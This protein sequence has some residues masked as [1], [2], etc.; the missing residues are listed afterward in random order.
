MD[1]LKTLLKQLVAIPSVNPDHTGPDDPG[2]GE[3]AFARFIRDY[4]KEQGIQS[5]LQKVAP[6]RHNVICRLPGRK[7]GQ[8]LIFLSHLDTI[9]STGMTVPPFKGIVKS[10]KLYGRGA[11]DPKASLAAML[12]ALVRIAQSPSKCDGEVLFV[13]TVGEEKDFVGVRKLVDSGI[14]ADACIVGEPT[15]L[16]LVVA[17]KGLV[18]FKITTTGKTAHG[19]TPEKGVNAIY[20]MA[21]VITAIEEYNHKLKKHSHP[22]L[23]SPTIVLGVINGGTAA[24]VVPD[25]CSIDI[26]MRLLPG[27]S[28]VS[29]IRKLSTFLRSHGI[30]HFKIEKPHLA[31]APLEQDPTH[32]LIKCV[33]SAARD[34]S[35]K[36]PLTGASYGT[37]GSAMHAAGIPT[38]VFGPGNPKFAHAPDEHVVLNEAE[39]AVDIYEDIVRRMD[40]GIC[41]K[42]F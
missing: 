13:G 30:R 1:S 42:P 25:Q 18:R 41:G 3:A 14:H 32:P 21:P 16:K 38:V 5:K 4:A 12:L 10:G 15:S 22:L 24:N 29:E 8:R 2:G 7:S 9:S 20:R 39:K 17:H 23:G 37:D 6:G 26:D 19:S 36:C 34:N 40:H 31:D 11:C 27:M 33:Q 35:V 28:V